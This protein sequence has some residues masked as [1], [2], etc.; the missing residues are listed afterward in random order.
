MRAHAD[1]G[2]KNYKKKKKNGRENKST[3]KTKEESND[4]ICGKIG[5][6]I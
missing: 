3:S 2:V 5:D 1:R 6:N 4:A